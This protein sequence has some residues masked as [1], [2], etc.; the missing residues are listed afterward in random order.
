LLDAF[1]RMVHDWGTILGN[2]CV[3]TTGRDSQRGGLEKGGF[4]PCQTADKAL[5]LRLRGLLAVPVATGEMLV[6]R[7]SPKFSMHHNAASGDLQGQYQHECFEAEFHSFTIGCTTSVKSHGAT[8][9]FRRSE[10]LGSRDLQPQILRQPFANFGGKTIVHSASTDASD[11]HHCHRCR[12][13][14][15]NHQPQ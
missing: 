3:S 13:R 7:R 12:S 5:W 15:R 11:V 8:K 14:H 4:M 9:S 1:A 2:L 10:F 6:F